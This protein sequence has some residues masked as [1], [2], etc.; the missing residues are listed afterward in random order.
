[1]NHFLV[2]WV[3]IV[4]GTKGIKLV[5]RYYKRNA[6]SLWGLLRPIST[7]LNTL[8]LESFILAGEWPPW[9]LLP[10]SFSN[11]TIFLLAISNFSFNFTTFFSSSWTYS[12]FSLSSLIVLLSFYFLLVSFTISLVKDNF[13]FFD[14]SSYLFSLSRS[15][16]FSWSLWHYF[17]FIY[18]YFSKAL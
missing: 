14:N 13:F 11:W 6:L 7:L 18:N 4:G 9:G 12:L 3:K 2:G 1:M 15:A 10:F 16:T 8:S 5:S 17:L